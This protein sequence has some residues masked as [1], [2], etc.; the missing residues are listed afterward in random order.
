MFSFDANSKQY[1]FHTP[2]VSG[3]SEVLPAGHYKLSL[4]PKGSV[5]FSPTAPFKLPSKLYGSMDARWDKVMRAYKNQ[6]NKNTGVLL[7]GRAG[8]G[9][10]LLGQYGAN[11]FVLD[12]EGGVVLM[13]EHAIPGPILSD[14]IARIPNP[15]LFFGDEFEKMHSLDV[16]NT[17]LTTF[18]G[19]TT[20]GVLFVMTANDLDRVVPYFLDRPGRFLF[21]WP[22]FGLDDDFITGYAQDNLNNKDHVQELLR[23][24]YRIN[25]M[26]FDILRAIVGSCNLEN[27]SPEEAVEDLNVTV[28]TLQ[29][30]DHWHVSELILS[31]RDVTPYYIPR[32]HG[33]DPRTLNNET[34]CI[35]GNYVGE[36]LASLMLKQAKERLARIPE[37]SMQHKILAERVR[38]LETGIRKTTFDDFF[39]P[40]IPATLLMRSDDAVVYAGDVVISGVSH[41]FKATWSR[42]V[43]SVMVK[44]VEGAPGSLQ[45]LLDHL[46]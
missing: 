13:P 23:L 45:A 36:E 46:S 22:Y 32:A 40:F 11:R 44:N 8:S 24:S 20:T 9:K 34:F 5:I 15:V 2:V 25:D 31:D 35:H 29:E 26:S 37:D 38:G 28:S 4:T 12:V 16:Q 42:G 33:V 27:I 17:L 1:T 14:I 18:D 19:G 39:L 7:T 41:T 30:N 6:P 43:R 21:H 3:V 10:S